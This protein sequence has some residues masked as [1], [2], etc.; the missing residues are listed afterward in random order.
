MRRRDVAAAAA[1]AAVLM[2]GRLVAQTP[3]RVRLGYLS[4]GTVDSLSLDILV[5]ALGERGWRSGETLDVEGRWADGDV[6]RLTALAA[7]LVAAHPDVLVS[8]G[9]SET[10]AL[11][12]ATATI[13]IVFTLV[14]DPVAAGIAQSIA[15]P[16]GNV[17]GF[18]Q[19]P[20]YLY[21]KQIDL[22]AALLGRPPRR[23]AW[24]GNPAN[25][26]AE[27]NWRDASDAARRLGTD[28]V[29]IDIRAAA[30]VEPALMAIAGCDAAVV[31]YEP[32]A[33]SERARIAALAAQLRLPTI[34]GS[35]I[36]VLA[37]GLMS[38][39]ADLRYNLREAAR[40]VQLIVEGTSPGELPI[41]QASRFEL[42]AAQEKGTTGGRPDKHKHNFIR[43]IVQLYRDAKGI[44]T[45][46][47]Q[48]AKD[49]PVPWYDPE[50]EEWKGELLDFVAACAVAPSAE[51]A[52]HPER[53][54]KIAYPV[55]SRN[56]GAR[57]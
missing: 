13:P 26:A 31:F 47:G 40:Y 1:A 46:G 15:R 36:H 37:G 44:E 8:T 9:L 50:A 17:T 35:R 28:I 6:S 42:R 55:A 51:I 7:E 41:V 30:E 22:L 45:K 27:F 49:L 32:L 56:V 20:Q 25:P 29:R 23:L 48:L 16:G 33:A 14:V 53:C 21:G 52:R 12:A 2:S 4:G 5:A 57:P 39:G 54:R 10:L 34:Y 11:H 18:S 3:R 19:G 24:I 38:Y 43:T